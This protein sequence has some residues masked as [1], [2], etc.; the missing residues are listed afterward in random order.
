[1]AW[2]SSLLYV[3]RSHGGG[4]RVSHG[5]MRAESGRLSVILGLHPANGYWSGR[6]KMCRAEGSTHGK[7]SK[8]F[9]AEDFTLTRNGCHSRLLRCRSIVAHGCR[10]NSDRCRPQAHPRV[11]QLTPQ[12]HGSLSAQSQKTG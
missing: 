4:H 1:M 6:S 12:D 11:A 5:L 10:T 3:H 2:E 7:E 8:F 9:D